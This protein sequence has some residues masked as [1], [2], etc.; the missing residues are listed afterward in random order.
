MTATL[1]DPRLLLDAW[2][3]A[4][5]VPDCAVGAVLLHR[6]GGTADLAAALDLPLSA[7]SAALAR[8]QAASFGP[9]LDAVTACQGCGEDLEVTLPVTRFAAL[10]GTTGPVRVEGPDGVLDVRCPTTRDL[11]AVVTTS[12]PAAAL[13][14]RCVDPAV[15]VT[16]LDPATLAQVEA[17]AEQVAGAAAALVTTRCP[18]CEQEVRVDVDLAALLWQRVRGAVPALLADVADLAAAFGWGEADVLALSPLRRAAYLDLAR[19]VA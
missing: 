19:G 16:D 4:A 15:D 10:A 5:A 13:L 6:A 8:L 12:D 1:A 17:A 9:V 14:A 2:E 3:A 18:A 11:V 7:L